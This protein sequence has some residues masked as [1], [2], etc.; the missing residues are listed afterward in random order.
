MAIKI[1][2]D[3]QMI[4]CVQFLPVNFFFVVLKTYSILL[5]YLGKEAGTMLLPSSEVEKWEHIF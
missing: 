2:G 3:I 1:P 5:C 4:L